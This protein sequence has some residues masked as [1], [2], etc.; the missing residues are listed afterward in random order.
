MFY[1]LSSCSSYRILSQKYCVDP[2]PKC[3]QFE[4]SKWAPAPILY[5]MVSEYMISVLNNDIL[6]I[7]VGI[8]L[9]GRSETRL[10]RVL[11]CNK[12]LIPGW[13]VLN[14]KLPLQAVLDL[15]WNSNLLGKHPVPGEY[16]IVRTMVALFQTILSVCIILLSLL[17]IREHL[18]TAQHQGWTLFKSQNTVE[19]MVSLH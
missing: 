18:Q 11:L 8:C 14:Y 3:K 9:C 16:I 2:A 1:C 17:F 10:T 5:M 6:I 13:S 4:H 15:D 7:L 19:I 12:C